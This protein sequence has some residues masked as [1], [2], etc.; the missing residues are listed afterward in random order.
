MVFLCE[1]FKLVPNFGKEY[2]AFVS[3]QGCFCEPFT[4]T[5]SNV[6]VGDVLLFLDQCAEEK[7]CA[8]TRI[9]SE[10]RTKIK[11]IIYRQTSK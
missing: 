2:S 5:V 11:T 9:E 8:K 3:I 10:N 7:M 4:G 1:A 6:L